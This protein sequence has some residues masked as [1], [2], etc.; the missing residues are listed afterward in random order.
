MIVKGRH[1]FNTLYFTVL[2]LPPPSLYK[3]FV[4]E[5]PCSSDSVGFLISLVFFPGF[6]LVHFL[7][8]SVGYRLADN[9]ATTKNVLFQFQPCL[10]APVERVF[11]Q[12]GLSM[13]PKQAKL[14][15][16]SLPALNCF[17]DNSHLSHVTSCWYQAVNDISTENKLYN[18]YNT[19][20]ILTWI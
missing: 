6:L 18:C 13:R 3:P 9:L 5:L 12:S 20:N 19:V 8:G 2:E 4:A 15:K 1:N 11:S 16:Y 7:F 14:G 17:W 10:H